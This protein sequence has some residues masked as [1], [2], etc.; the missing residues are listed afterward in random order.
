MKA[1]E[2]QPLGDAEPDVL[3][4]ICPALQDAFKVPAKVRSGSIPLSSFYDVQ[5]GQY[6]STAILH[7]LSPFLS[8]PRTGAILRSNSDIH[9]VGVTQRDLFM[10]ILTYVFGEAALGGDAAVVSY[11]R[12]RNELY[13]LP[14]NKDLMIERLRKV[15]IHEL[16]HTLGL[17]HCTLQYC[18]MHAAS[19]VE[20]L[21]LKGHEFCPF[22]RS[23]EARVLHS[24]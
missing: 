10:P 2:L 20:E 14:P 4:S 1:I 9:I 21:D 15:T 3:E 5:R 17:V 23:A 22:C 11:H 12:F 6:N 24:I 8:M 19:Y 7:Q 16:G 13:G 18:V